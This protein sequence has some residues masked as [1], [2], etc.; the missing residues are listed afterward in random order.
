MSRMWPYLNEDGN[1]Q[2]GEIVRAGDRAEEGEPRISRKD[3]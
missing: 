1:T 3:D 2:R